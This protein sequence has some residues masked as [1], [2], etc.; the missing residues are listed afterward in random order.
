MDVLNADLEDLA[1]VAAVEAAAAVAV[2]VAAEVGAE[3]VVVMAGEV[4]TVAAADAVVAVDGDAGLKSTQK[5]KL[6]NAHARKDGL[7]R[8]KCGQ[9]E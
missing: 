2:E 6:N 1:D 9:A 4:A 3:V 5:V 8:W 7:N